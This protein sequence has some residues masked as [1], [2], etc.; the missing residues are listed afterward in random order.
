MDEATVTPDDTRWFDR[1]GQRHDVLITLQEATRLRDECDLDLPK[2]LVNSRYLQPVYQKLH[3]DPSRVVSALAVIEDV[4]DPEHFGSLFDGDA[5]Q[6]ATDALLFAIAAF[7][8]SRQRRVILTLLTKCREAAEATSDRGMDAALDLMNQ[9]GFISEL[10]ESA[11]R[12]N[13]SND[14][15][16]SPDVPLAE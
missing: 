3:E 1:N 16:P 6:Q 15:W 9:P 4:E 5:L 2:A 13:G 10:S 12:G 7:F 14:S 11:T 8:P